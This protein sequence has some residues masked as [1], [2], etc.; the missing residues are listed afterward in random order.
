MNNNSN[1]NN[2]IAISNKITLI[3]KD[4]ENHI[5]K[6]DGIIDKD[7]A[8]V[9]TFIKSLF[10]EFNKEAEL[11]KKARTVLLQK[12]IKQIQFS[13]LELFDIKSELE[14]EWKQCEDEGEDMHKRIELYLKNNNNENELMLNKY[15]EDQYFLNF[16]KDNNLIVYKSEYMVYNKELKLAGTIDAMFIKRDLRFA[17]DNIKKKNI[18]LVDWKRIKLMYFSSKNNESAYY[19]IQDMPNTNFSKNSLQVNLYKY[20]LESSDEYNVT[21]MMV[22]CLH[23][24][25]KNYIQYKIPILLDQIQKLINERRLELEILNLDY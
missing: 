10:P 24:Q 23:E 18:I 19:P 3:E 17:S 16:M 13:E 2:D 14:Y 22:V 25:N 21:D 11:N 20:L 6:V 4:E 9:T 5:Y 8:S 15:K 1:N 12:G 7:V